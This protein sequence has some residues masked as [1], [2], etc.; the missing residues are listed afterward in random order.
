MQIHSAK[1]NI[2]NMKYENSHINKET[3]QK[4]GNSIQISYLIWSK[5]QLYRPKVQPQ[6]LK[7]TTLLPNKP[8]SAR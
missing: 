4:S 8:A 1:N 3:E 2:R 7:A 5:Q 6:E